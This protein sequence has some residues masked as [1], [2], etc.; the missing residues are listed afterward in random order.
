MWDRGGEELDKHRSVMNLQEFGLFLLANFSDVLSAE[1][2]LP[3]PLSWLSPT[4][5]MLRSRARSSGKPSL[6]SL[7]SKSLSS[8]FP[9]P[10]SL[11]PQ[12]CR[13]TVCL[14]PPPSFARK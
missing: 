4:P 2:G 3:P 11:I 8:G 10:S 13:W 6:I 7:Q 1:R 12:Q 5:S 9:K 14:P